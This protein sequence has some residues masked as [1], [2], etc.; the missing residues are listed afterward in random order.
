MCVG[1]SR[2]SY[3]NF[4]WF[5][6]QVRYKIQILTVHVKKQAELALLD[7]YPPQA[8]CGQE[9]FAGEKFVFSH[10]LFPVVWCVKTLKKALISI[11]T[12]IK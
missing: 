4:S 9:T 12:G 1:V 6:S 7:A 5:I 11:R 8:R 2:T 3:Q 10:C